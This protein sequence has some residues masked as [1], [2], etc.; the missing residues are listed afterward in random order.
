MVGGSRLSVKQRA[1]L[2]VIVEKSSRKSSNPGAF[3]KG[4]PRIRRGKGPKKGAANAGRPPDEIRKA[5]R[6]AFE[7]R[8]HVL[9]EIA[10]NKSEESGIRIKALE[11]LGKYGLGT[12]FTP[13]DT[14]GNDLAVSVT[15]R[16]IRPSAG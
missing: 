11:T 6:L 13:T 2:L 3:T 7:E 15:H 1:S 16:V 4:D 10:D 14:Q 9:S 12:T 8:L 5:C